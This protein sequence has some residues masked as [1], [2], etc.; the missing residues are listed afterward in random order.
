[1]RNCPISILNCQTVQQ[2]YDE[3]ADVFFIGF[4]ATPQQD[5]PSKDYY[6]NTRRLLLQG[7][8]F[9]AAISNWVAVITKGECFCR[10]QM[11]G[12]TPLP[13]RL[14]KA[15]FVAVILNFVAVHHQINAVN[16]AATI[17]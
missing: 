3:G 5:V 13:P 17:I 1:M 8:D 6:Q 11:E 14:C 4:K 9:L 7:R 15:A 2:Y 16:F 12:S 10:R